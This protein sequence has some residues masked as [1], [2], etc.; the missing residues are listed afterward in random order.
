MDTNNRLTK[1]YVSSF[2]QKR[3]S[4]QRKSL[5]ILGIIIILTALISFLLVDYLSPLP[6]DPRGFII[7]YILLLVGIILQVIILF[8]NKT[9]NDNSNNIALLGVVP[10]SRR[11]PLFGKNFVRIREHQPKTLLGW[12]SPVVTNHAIIWLSTI[13]GALIAT[14]LLPG[15][16][17]K[18]KNL[19]HQFLGLSIAVG[20]AIYITLTIIALKYNWTLMIINIINAFI[21]GLSVPGF[22]TIFYSLGSIIFPTK[23][24]FERVTW[25]A[26][27]IFSTWLFIAFLPFPILERLT[28]RIIFNMASGMWIMLIF[29][30]INQISDKKSSKIVVK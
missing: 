6:I 11:K 21:I 5:L 19:L 4:N 12:L 1:K 2:K 18:W 17:R 29:F 28:F 9:S 13:P 8:I 30:Y 22:S 24:T 27:L 3:A 7:N 25:G 26:F 20:S 14:L 10:P 15:E 23:G 16:V